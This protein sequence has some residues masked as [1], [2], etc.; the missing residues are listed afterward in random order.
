MRISYGCTC[1][2][3]FLFLSR[4]LNQNEIADFLTNNAHSSDGCLK[5]EASRALSP[6]LPSKPDAAVLSYTCRHRPR[7]TRFKRLAIDAIID[8]QIRNALHRQVQLQ[9]VRPSY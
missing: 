6:G 5:D 1:T 7:P 2:D 8:G 3:Y 9:W 4:P